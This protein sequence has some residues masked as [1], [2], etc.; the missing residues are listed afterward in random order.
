VPGTCFL[1]RLHGKRHGALDSFSFEE[2]VPG[3][4][5]ANAEMQAHLNA[6]GAR[7]PFSEHVA[8][9][10]LVAEKE[11]PVRWE[12]FVRDCLI[13][14]ARTLAQ[15]GR[16]DEALNATLAALKASRLAGWDALL[17]VP[18]DTVPLLTDI[19]Q[20]QALEKVYRAC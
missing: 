9:A 20:G 15:A 12:R 10:I 7:Q 18:K 6:C 4:W 16:P 11:A 8:P 3:T 17:V 1:L 14:T 2:Q 19:D 13:G 5:P